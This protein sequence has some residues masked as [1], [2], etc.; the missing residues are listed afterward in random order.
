MI[1][2]I[3]QHIKKYNADRGYFFE[4]N[5]FSFKYLKFKYSE[6]HNIIDKHNEANDQKKHKIKIF[7]DK[8]IESTVNYCFENKYFTT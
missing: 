8:L 7:F 1:K 3:N 6:A 5:L 4:N 2:Q